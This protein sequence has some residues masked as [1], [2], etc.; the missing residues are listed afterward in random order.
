MIPAAFQDFFHKVYDSR[1]SGLLHSLQQKE[2]QIPRRNLFSSGEFSYQEGQELPRGPE[3]LLHF[4]IMDAASMEV[5]R[6]LQV[7]KGDA[8][9]DMCAAP[10]GKTLI[11]AEAL[12]GEGQ[13]LANEISQARRER[14]KKVIQQYVPREQ[15]EHIRVTG[16]DGGKFALTHA[17]EFDRILVDAPCSGERHLLQNAK[18]LSLWS[19]SRSKKLAQRQYALLTAA[20][21]VAK[22]GA[23]IV[24]STCSISPY[25]NDLVI[26]KLLEKKSGFSV[27]DY[28]PQLAGAEKTKQGWMWLPDQSG[29]GPI[30]L[31]VLS[32]N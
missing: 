18:E 2:S 20:L 13:L 14:L 6:A 16:K 4:Y 1:W 15:R 17:H 22:P 27:M 31:C 21:L 24:Y 26:E 12:R 30:Y 28:Q 11:L 3:N 23:R 32:V 25:E 29:F 5:A 19:E 9:L 10:G 7:Q 8:V